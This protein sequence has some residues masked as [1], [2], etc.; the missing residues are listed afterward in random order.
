MTG[1]NLSLFRG[2]TEVFIKIRLCTATVD[3]GLCL[4]LRFV[5][6]LRSPLL[7]FPRNTTVNPTHS[8]SVQN[9]TCGLLYLRSL[10]PPFSSFQFQFLCFF[11]FHYFCL[12]RIFKMS[13]IPN[14]L[15]FGLTHGKAKIS[16][17]ERTSEMAETS[18]EDNKVPTKR[19]KISDGLATVP[20][21]EPSETFAGTL[22]IFLEADVAG[23]FKLTPWV[24]KIM[25][26]VKE[27][28][29]LV[30]KKKEFTTEEKNTIISIFNVIWKRDEGEKKDSVEVPSPGVV[31]AEWNSAKTNAS[32]K[33]PLIPTFM[34]RC[35]QRKRLVDNDTV[36]TCA[37]A[38]LLEISC[39]TDDFVEYVRNTCRK[40]IFGCCVI[41]NDQDQLRELSGKFITDF[42]TEMQ[43]IATWANG[44]NRVGHTLSIGGESGSGKTRAALQCAKLL[45]GRDSNGGD[46]KDYLT[47][48]IKLSKDDD[49]DLLHS[50]VASYFATREEGDAAAEFAKAKKLTNATTVDRLL[51]EGSEPDNER[52]MLR[53]IRARLCFEF[54][55]RKINEITGYSVFKSKK[56]F[57]QVFFVFDE[58]GICPWV[59]RSVNQVSSEGNTLASFFNHQKEFSDNFM[60][61]CCSTATQ[62]LYRNMLSTQSSFDPV[63]MRPGRKVYEGIVEGMDDYKTRKNFIGRLVENP[64]FAKLVENRGCGVVA[65][66]VVRNAVEGP[67]RSWTWKV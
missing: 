54:V 56:A 14:P 66:E 31:A 64:F 45:K 59:Y 63:I 35:L 16:R 3:E 29:E 24:D 22:K 26:T 1:Y 23:D 38:L 4:R 42:S 60:V 39:T 6:R 53:L 47:V 32:E 33:N 2:L 17:D 25:G 55:R 20:N 57:K 52:K 49:Q 40:E 18:S 8:S 11:Y 10:S 51:G 37:A 28:E 61:V 12:Y 15:I 36:L 13:D 9:C 65:A 27:K 58:A 48:Y 5:C 67:L 41:T 7:E 50:K 44:E 19:V 46:D 21:I 34:R 43:H 30:T 62:G